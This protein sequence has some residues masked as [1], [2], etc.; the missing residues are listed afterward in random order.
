MQGNSWWLKQKE[1]K[2]AGKKYARKFPASKKKSNPKE[3]EE[4]SGIDTHMPFS[5]SKVWYRKPSYKTMNEIIQ[6]Q[7]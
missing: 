3:E 6:G 5:S 7:G 4:E 1:K 2:A